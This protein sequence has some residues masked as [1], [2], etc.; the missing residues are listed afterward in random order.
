MAASIK[1]CTIT[2]PVVPMEHG[3]EGSQVDGVTG[4]HREIKKQNALYHQRGSFHTT[5]IL[6]IASVHAN[7]S[8][9]CN[10]VHSLSC[11][12]D[13]IYTSGRL[14]LCKV[15]SSTPAVFLY[16]GLLLVRPW[17][18]FLRGIKFS[19]TCLPDLCK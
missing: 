7:S 17:G 12:F 4:Q 1:C 2:F 11:T 19:Q 8:V 18:F 6:R 3:A 14:K 13:H 10:I 5:R 15:Q 16:A 9:A